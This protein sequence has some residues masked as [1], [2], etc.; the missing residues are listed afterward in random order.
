MVDL[1][2]DQPFGEMG[3]L[4][5]SLRVSLQ[6]LSEFG[7]FGRRQIR[8]ASLS[9]LTNGVKPEKEELNQRRKPQP[10]ERSGNGMIRTKRT[11]KWTRETKTKIRT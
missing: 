2:A 7:L 4:L 3:V 1:L 10:A 8:T 9:S 6:S 11:Q 5:A